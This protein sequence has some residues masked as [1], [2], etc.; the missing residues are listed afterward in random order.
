MRKKSLI[1]ILLFMAHSIILF[2]CMKD[3]DI[4][5]KAKATQ[6]IIASNRDWGLPSPYLIVPR[7]P[8]FVRLQ[9]VFDSLVWKDKDGNL[10]PQ[11]AKE[12]KYDKDKFEYSFVLNENIKWHD[13]EKLNADDVVFTVNYMK[14]HKLSWIDLSIIDK[15]IR[16]NEYEV[17]FKL[18]DHYSPFLS[19]IGNGMVIIPEHIYS[20][21]DDPFGTFTKDVSIGS[22]PFVLESYSP[23]EG[24]YSF[25]A[26]SDYYN[27]SQ[28]FEKIKFLSIGMEMQSSAIINGE[29]DLIRPSGD[30][31]DKLLSEGFNNI[32]SYGLGVRLKFNTKRKPFDNKNMRQ[33]IAYAIDTDE[34]I[35]IAQRGYAYSGDTGLIRKESEFY[36]EDVKEYPLSIE[37]TKDLMKS[38]GYEK[39]EGYYSKDGEILEIELLG[40]DIVNRDMEVIAS[41]LSR[42]GFKI[43]LLF[44]DIPTCEEL[45]YDRNFDIAFA[46]DAMTGDPVYLNSIILP[47]SGIGDY[48]DNPRLKELLVKQVSTFDNNERSKYLRE[49]QNI[50]S[51][52][53][54]SYQLFYYRFDTVFNDKMDVYY[55]KSGIG[56]GVPHP[57]NKLMYLE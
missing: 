2:G 30:G 56:F 26:F 12:W 7:G 19:S 28:L 34:V 5:D 54:P 16:K 57:F 21:I 18:K 48:I 6:Y 55:T 49:I 23:E 46:S 4:D 35:K 14:K 37:K 32:S 8:A 36:S 9:L 22:G 47:D 17:V 29:V 45:I 40:Y 10:I 31:V 25:K 38:L 43:K 3:W 33:A 15:A 44:K 41:Q 39:E 20:K 52:E 1:L 24:N 27:G 51:E 42:A 53:L 13:G 50:Y 11:L